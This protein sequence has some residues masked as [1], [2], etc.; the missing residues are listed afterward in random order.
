[1]IV[2]AVVLAL[3][4]GI[5]VAGWAAWAFLGD[6]DGDGRTAPPP[7][8]SA[9]TAAPAYPEE[10][11][12]FYEQDLD[13]KDC[14]PRECTRLEVPLDYADPDGKVIKLAVLRVPAKLRDERVGQL[15]VNPGGPGASALNY[16]NSGSFNFGEKLIRYFDIVGVDPRG[17]G[18]STPIECAGT[19]QTDE[20]LSADPDPET[21]DEVSQLDR[22][23]REL[24]EGCLSRSGALTR[25]ISTVEVAKDMDILRAALGERQLDYLGA[26]YGTL[27]GA[28]YAD[29]FPTHVRRMVLD[30][31]VDPSLSKEELD[32]GQAKGFET[33]LRAYLQDCLDAS[34][35]IL[36]ESVDE[37]KQRIRQLLDEIDASPLPTSSD[38]RLT[39]GLALYGIILPLYSKSYWPLLT[40]ALGQAINGRGDGLLTLADQYASRGPDGYEDNSIQAIYAVNCLDHND[41]IPTSEVPAHFADFEKA[42]P[43]FGRVFAYGLSTCASWPV[44]SGNRTEALAAA[45]APPIVVIGTTRDPATPYEQAV[46]LARQLE[47]GVLITRD[48]DGHTG[49]NKGNRCVDDA[50]E[51]Y[52]LAGEKPKDGLSC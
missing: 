31:A 33:A 38:R 9:T 44:K 4:I 28:T 27:I 18:K 22:L 40:E 12:R 23:T 46:G 8:P 42:S 13:W 21:S 24:G 50:V 52:L 45:G 15:V 32:L 36:G 6:G 26:S 25:H 2:G 7:E 51:S 16:A 39:E 37:G 47:S 29:L 5:G 49:F 43:T 3:V 14:G 48:G 41:Y 1:V 11:A 19:E 35:C 10:L 17:V 30:G 20:L 34:S